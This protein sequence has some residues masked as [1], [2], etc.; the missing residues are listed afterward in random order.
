MCVKF[1]LGL[2]LT[3]P[4]ACPEWPLFRAEAESGFLTSD[5][6]SAPEPR[7]AQALCSSTLRGSQICST[8]ADSCPK[9]CGPARWSVV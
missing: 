5:S 3:L 4:G 8:Q 9:P 2:Q 6:P 7:K 1:L